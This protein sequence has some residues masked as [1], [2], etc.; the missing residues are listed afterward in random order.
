MICDD[1]APY[2]FYLRSLLE[3]ERDLD[4]VGE[5][6]HG[7]QAIERCRDLQPDILVIDLDMPV[8]DGYTAMQRVRVV[9]PETRI[10]VLTGNDLGVVA[11]TSSTSGADLVFAKS[12]APD[13]IVAALRALATRAVTTA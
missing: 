4:V 2:R 12:T 7:G 6:W 9:A 11:E 3:Q 1:Q 10:C 5:G 8:M 13:E